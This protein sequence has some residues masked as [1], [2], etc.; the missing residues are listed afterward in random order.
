M[1]SASVISPF[2]S[3]HPRPRVQVAPGI[4]RVARKASRLS[5]SKNVHAIDKSHA[6]SSTPEFP[7][8]ET[9]KTTNAIK[10]EH[11]LYLRHILKREIRL[12]LIQRRGFGKRS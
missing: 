8:A 9:W 5:P 3:V 12:W 4:E 6:G 10:E 11:S 1:F 7:C 2:H